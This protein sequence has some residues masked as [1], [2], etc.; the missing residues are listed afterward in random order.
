MAGRDDLALRDLLIKVDRMVPIKI[1]ENWND[2][3]F[4]AAQ[5]WATTV[6]GTRRSKTPETPAE[7]AHV[8]Q[9]A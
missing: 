4:R 2:E 8:K 6:F 7:P 5:A 9:W 3:E 1:L